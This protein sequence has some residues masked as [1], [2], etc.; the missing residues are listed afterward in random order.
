MRRRRSPEREAAEEIAVFRDGLPKLEAQHAA[1]EADV[2]NARAAR[3][4][5]LEELGD[6]LALGDADPTDVEHR[7]R[8]LD[9]MVAAAEGRREVLAFAVAGARRRGRDAAERLGALRIAEV[10]AAIEQRESAIADLERA[11]ATERRSLEEDYVRRERV[12]AEAAALRTPF[13]D[14]QERAA[15][16]EQRQNEQRQVE[17]Y[18]RDHNPHV[19]VPLHLRERVEEQRRRNA[20]EDQRRRER[21]AERAAATRTP[22]AE[23]PFEAA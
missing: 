13:A 17:W 23:S 6:A 20:L 18:A 3:E 9:S 10:D 15:A 2:S 4:R 12:A 1:A 14:E 5:E 16:A 11:L 7:R 21:N 22:D 19:E 8:E